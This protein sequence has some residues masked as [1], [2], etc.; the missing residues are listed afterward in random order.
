MATSIVTNAD[1]M[2]K[3]N[4][5][6]SI[7]TGSKWLELANQK[8]V[9]TINSN[10]TSISDA[11]AEAQAGIT[12]A[13]SNADTAMTTANN[14]LS[15][16]Q[17]AIANVQTV[18]DTANDAITVANNAISQAVSSLST[19]VSGKVDTTTYTSKITELANS[20]ASKVSQTDY[21]SEITQLSTAIDAKV[22]S[23]DYNTEVT[24]L[25]NQISAKVSQSDYDSEITQLSTDINLK[26]SKGDVISQ[27]NAEADNILIQSSK[28]YL[29]ADSIVFGGTAFI[30]E[31][32]ISSINADTI[33]T[34]I[35]VG[36]AMKLDFTNGTINVNDTF[37]VDAS[38]NLTATSASLIGA[39]KVNT[40]GN[41]TTVDSDGIHNTDSDG[42]DIYIKDG[43]FES[44]MYDEAYNATTTIKV[45]E[46]QVTAS[47]NDESISL[48]VGRTSAPGIQWNDSSVIESSFGRLTVYSESDMNISSSS[49]NINLEASGGNVQVTGGGF[50]NTAGGSRTRN[51][52]IDNELWVDGNFSVSGTKNAIVETT[53]GWVNINAYE[54]AEYYFGDLGFANTGSGSKVKITMDSLFLETVNTKVDYHIFVSSYGNGYA[55]IS[56]QTDTYFVIESNVPDLKV[57]YEVKAKRLGYENDRLEIN[58]AM[59]NV[60][61]AA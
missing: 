2:D 35:A 48:L 59:E 33:T 37:E 7:W 21:D 51:H 57:S 14:A 50:I 44:T 13:S 22:S 25:S 36:N 4:A 32:M 27:I 47:Y 38:G 26:V 60:G 23:D 28:L 6:V 61:A 56:E 34:G 45:I 53:V 42:N 19:T 58:T 24:L 46:G 17:T 40:S 8:T 54:T 15:N 49:G 31:A 43:Y 16:A 20:I 30:T 29:D 39:L 1:A 9:N 11:V 52:R 12:T 41:T 3:V 18:S 10:I 55:W 5:Q